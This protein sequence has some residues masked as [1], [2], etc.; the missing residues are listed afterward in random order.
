MG[1]AL[2]GFNSIAVFC[3]GA[4]RF[5]RFADQMQASRRHTNERI[6]RRPLVLTDFLVAAAPP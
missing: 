3:W 4:R 6:A 1:G 2:I 5:R